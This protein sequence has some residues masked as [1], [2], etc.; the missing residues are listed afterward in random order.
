MANVLNNEKKQQIL[1]L[2]DW[3]GPCVA[4]G[5]HACSSRNYQHVPEGGG[6]GSVA[7]WWVGT[8]NRFKAA[9]AATTGFGVELRARD[10][11]L[12]I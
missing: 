7:G 12:R 6:R 8:T 9:R 3:A 5:G 2:G 4:S 10:P 1:A 11:K